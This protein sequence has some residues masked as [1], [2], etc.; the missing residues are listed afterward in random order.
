MCK[1]NNSVGLIV[2][3]FRKMSPYVHNIIKQCVLSCG[4][5]LGLTKYPRRALHLSGLDARFGGVH[6]YGP[7]HF[8]PLATF[9]VSF[10]KF[11]LYSPKLL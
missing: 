8:G 5:Q 7:P 9:L 6:F 4:P 1:C 3:L 11:G 10:A 2:V